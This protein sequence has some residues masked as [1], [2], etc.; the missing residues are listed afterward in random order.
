MAYQAR[1]ESKYQQSLELY[2]LIKGKEDAF[3]DYTN[4]SELQGQ[5]VLGLANSSS[6][7]FG[8]NFKRYEPVG[9]NGLSL[10]MEA[11]P[12]NNLIRWLERLD[13]QYGIKVNEIDVDRKNNQSTVDVR[14]VLQ[15]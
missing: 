1:A 8:F 6:K 13:K 9:E 4:S 10:W 3:S 12:F 15:G 2:S 5:S 11:V 14:L 7:S